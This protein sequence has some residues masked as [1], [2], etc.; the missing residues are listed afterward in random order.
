MQNPS[1]FKS[2][3]RASN[4]EVPSQETGDFPERV[5]WGNFPQIKPPTYG[6]FNRLESRSSSLSSSP[7]SCLHPSVLDA[8]GRHPIRPALSRSLYWRIS[9]YHMTK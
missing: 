7:V 1:S 8:A 6:K 3:P 4:T 5:V 2:L 9:F